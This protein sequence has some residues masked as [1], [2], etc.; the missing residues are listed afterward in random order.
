VETTASNC[1][2]GNGRASASAIWK[3][4]SAPAFLAFFLALAIISDDASIP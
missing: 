4:T 3:D 2:S 1:P